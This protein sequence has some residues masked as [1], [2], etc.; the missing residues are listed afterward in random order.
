MTKKIVS[1]NKLVFYFLFS[2]LVTNVTVLAQED[3]NKE[4][5]QL[6]AIQNEIINI[7]SKKMETV[8]K[9][10]KPGFN[11]MKA[12]AEE[13]DKIKDEKRKK[14]AMDNYQKAHKAHYMKMMSSAGVNINSVLAHL[15]KK[16]PGYSFSSSDGISIDI[17]KTVKEIP[18][19]SSDAGFI[20]EMNENTGGLAMKIS[21][22]NTGTGPVYIDLVEERSIRLA[23]SKSINCTLVSGGSVDFWSPNSMR[24]S[25]FA[26]IAGGCGARGTLQY[27]FTVPSGLRY[28]KV[29]LSGSLRQHGYVVATGGLSLIATE[30]SVDIYR[31]SPKKTL[32]TNYLSKYKV[33]PILWAAGFDESRSLYGNVDVSSYKTQGVIIKATAHTY[34][35][36]EVVSST[37]GFCQ[38]NLPTVKKVFERL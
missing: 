30:T 2:M 11:K 35:I 26:A 29:V 33:A 16:F 19:E 1:F 32:F 21:G 17:E 28:L 38:I 31:P 27:G 5:E 10:D 4:K 6:Q 34:N 18:Q 7:Y 22:S 36:S 3:D 8:L 24:A 23:P 9:K 20:G 12:D 14:D 15:K 13:I 37:I 25:S